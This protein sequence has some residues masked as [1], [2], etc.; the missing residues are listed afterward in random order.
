MFAIT[1]PLFRF[2]TFI[3]LSKESPKTCKNKSSDREFVCIAL[4]KSSCDS[5]FQR[6]FTALFSSLARKI[7]FIES[8]TGFEFRFGNSGLVLGSD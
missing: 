3:G 8:A 6:A 7:S 4:V 5:R 2:G 1:K